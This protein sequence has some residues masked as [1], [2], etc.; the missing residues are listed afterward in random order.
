MFLG[1]EFQ[2]YVL[3]LVCLLESL[4]SGRKLLCVMSLEGSELLAKFKHKLFLL[5][6][7]CKGA[8]KLYEPTMKQ[9]Y[10]WT[11]KEIALKFL[12]FLACSVIL[13][14]SRIC[15]CVRLF[16]YKLKRAVLLPV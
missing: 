16:M 9:M 10:L 11:S 3:Q 13:I 7:L 12:L 14:S 2:N 4:A 6:D 15:S 8:T 1:W 5:F